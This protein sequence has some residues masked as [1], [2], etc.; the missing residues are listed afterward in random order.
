MELEIVESASLVPIR[1]VKEVTEVLMTRRS[2]WNP[3]KSRPMRWPGEW[4]FAGGVKDPEDTDLS[5]TAIR[6]FQE[7]TFYRGPFENIRLLRGAEL[8]S[9]GRIYNHFFFSAEIDPF[10]AFTDFQTDEVI[11]IEW[12][13]PGQWLKYL[14][15]DEFDQLQL[16]K[17]S[18]L[19]LGD[20]Q[21]G[22]FSVLQREVPD[23]TLYTLEAIEFQLS[24]PGAQL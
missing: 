22:A 12:R 10:H 6:E 3:L 17:F 7:E 11:G 15:S 1:K 5:S 4:V 8:R 16:Q 23:Q 18:E 13:S 24:N 9:R 14:R 20:Q 21:F 19:G 2:F